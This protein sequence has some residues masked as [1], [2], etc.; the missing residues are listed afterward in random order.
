MKVTSIQAIALVTMGSDYFTGREANGTP[1]STGIFRRGANVPLEPRRAFVDGYVKT[2]AHL[3]RLTKHVVF[4]IDVPE[5]DFNPRNCVLRSITIGAPRDC[6][7]PRSQ[8]DERQR[9]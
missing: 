5:L 8:F 4:V 7:L 9:E 1:I 2:I 3:I 6:Y